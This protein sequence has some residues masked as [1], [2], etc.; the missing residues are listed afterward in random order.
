[1]ARKASQAISSTPQSLSM[2]WTHHLLVYLVIAVMAN[3]IE[4]AFELLNESL[5][6]L[7]TG[8]FGLFN[9]TTRGN[10]QDI[11]MY[12]GIT[13]AA[14]TVILCYVN[15]R[16]QRK[17]DANKVVLI[18]GCDSGLGYNIAL[19]CHALNMTVVAACHNECSEGARQLQQKCSKRLRVIELD[20]TKKESVMKA[21]TCVRN[22]LADDHLL[23]E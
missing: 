2:P 7:G 13:T 23:S 12:A 10:L 14:A 17:I 1:M 3:P 21:H 6:Y 11:M 16:E 18:T 15:A 20:I 5:V 4:A 9:V 22:M 19:K 8:I